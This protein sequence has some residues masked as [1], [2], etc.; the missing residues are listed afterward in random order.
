MLITGDILKTMKKGAV[1]IDVS[2]DQGGC[3]ETSKPTT[4]DNPVYE[5]DVIIHYCVANMPGAY[6]RTSTLVLTN[7]TLPYIKLLANKG[8]ENVLRED[9]IIKMALNTHRGEITNNAVAE[10][11]GMPC[12]GS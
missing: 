10:S 2:I 9:A 3:I 1:I 11:K 8:I 5:V 12:M 4:H 7:A 6:P